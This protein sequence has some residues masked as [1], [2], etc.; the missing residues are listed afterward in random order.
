LAAQ[1]EVARLAATLLARGEIMGFVAP[2]NGPLTV[3]VVR[4]SLNGLA[5]RGVATRA[6][7]GVDEDHLGEAIE[8]A[9][10][11]TEHSPMPA[12]EW[13]SLLETLGE[14]L[15]ARLVCISP[16]SLRRYAAGAR[17]APDIVVGRLHTLA[18]VVAD[19]AGAYNDCGIRRWFAR[20]RI[21]LE[22][23]SPEG[24]L[25]GEWDADGPE[26]SRVRR[27]AAGVVGASAS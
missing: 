11:G 2:F 5:A 10:E 6:A 17:R 1:P 8:L 18:L 15:L 21:V 19:L 26:A 27:L 13:A 24:V 9:L 20:P 22:G 12:G 4:D 3:E 7:V 16:S 14:D 25:A 23:R